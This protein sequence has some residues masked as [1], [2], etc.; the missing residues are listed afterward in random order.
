MQF[1]SYHFAKKKKI[2]SVHRN[3][4]YYC[5]KEREARLEMFSAETPSHGRLK[6]L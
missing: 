2:E 1:W 3:S 6:V 4:A 5:D